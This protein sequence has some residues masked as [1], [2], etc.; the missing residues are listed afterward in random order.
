MSGAAFDDLIDWT[1]GGYY[2][3]ADNNFSGSNILYPG[4]PFQNLNGP[5]DDITSKNKS[6][7]AQ[8]ILHPTDRFNVTG[9]IRYT[10]D[11]KDYIYRRF[12]PFMP[13]VPTYTPAGILTGVT[14]DYEAN[15]VDY[16]LSVDYRWSS[17]L[18]T[19][20]QVS[21][22]FRGGG[23][24]SRPFVPEQAVPFYPE[25]MTAYEVGFKSDLL[26]RRLRVNGSFF[27][28]D[29]QDIIFTNL[30]P[31]PNSQNNATPTNV[32]T[33]KFKGA[34]LEITTRPVDGLLI[35]GSI[36][37]L[38]FQ[39][40]SFTAT[41]VTII[42]VTLDSKA[43]F[44]SKWKFAAGVQYAVETE[45]GTITPRLDYNYQSS[46]YTNI[47]N[48]PLSMVPRRGI[49]NARITFDSLD[50][51]WRLSI[52][53]KNLF[54]KYYYNNRFFNVGLSSAQPAPPREISVTLRRN[55]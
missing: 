24:N 8:L 51:D 54:D 32:G 50:K 39:L 2:Y 27:I 18:M 45:I 17:E 40:K 55:F 29:Y 3:H 4:K 44:V 11:S 31:T 12:N 16:R 37:Y 13:G 43:P 42:G 10:N 1:V 22:G 20:A 6:L 36:S 14:S 15:K 53:A 19:Y 23:T 9:G 30:S 46:F 48:D 25:T 52:A 21:T 26:D 7:F 49:F 47:N 33:A 28:N 35:D 34:E 5:D 38:D 41:G